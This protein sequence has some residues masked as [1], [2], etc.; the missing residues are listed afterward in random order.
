MRVKIRQAFQGEVHYLHKK[1]DQCFVDRWRFIGENK[2]N[3]QIKHLSSPNFFKSSYR[4]FNFWNFSHK[5][6]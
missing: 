4:V 5:H 2:K 3:V 1:I 6:L